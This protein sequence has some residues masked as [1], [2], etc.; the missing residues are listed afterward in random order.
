MCTLSTAIVIGCAFSRSTLFHVTAVLVNEE[1]Y[2]SP[3][4]VGLTYPN[5]LG[6]ELG[7]VKW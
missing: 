4:Q 1:N 6:D 7:I 2:V 5:D 3:I